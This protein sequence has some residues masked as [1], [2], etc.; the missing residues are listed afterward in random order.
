MM[1]RSLLRSL[2]VALSILSVCAAPSAQA[3]T[4]P[5]SAESS[6]EF[7]DVGALYVEGLMTLDANVSTFHFTTFDMALGST[8]SFVNLVSGDPLRL[9]ASESIRINGALVFSPAT[10]LYIEAPLVELG[11]SAL[12]AAPGGSVTLVAGREIDGTRV[13]GTLSLLPGASIDVSGGGIVRS[14][15]AIRV[16]ESGNLSLTSGGIVTLRAPVPE[17]ETWAMLLA[18][19]GLVGVAVARRR[20]GE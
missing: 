6:T 18:G 16:D 3:S 8:L 11:E 13:G 17:A 20:S 7:V 4:I 10:A 5:G 19:L 1:Y 9:I 14:T 12:I 2:A 15:D